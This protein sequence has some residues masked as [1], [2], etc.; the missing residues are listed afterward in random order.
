MNDFKDLSEIWFCLLLAD[1]WTMIRSM[2]GVKWGVKFKHC[3]MWGYDK[4][5]GFE[6][7]GLLK[8]NCW[9]ALGHIGHTGFLVFG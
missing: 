7:D 1:G 3:M 8:G 4:K 9:G 6:S 2:L 5:F